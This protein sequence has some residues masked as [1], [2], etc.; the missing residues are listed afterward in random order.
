[1]FPEVEYDNI[2]LTHGM[3]ITIVTTT[4]NDKESFKLL[5][6]LG[7]PFTKGRS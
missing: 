1:M 2:L 5:E 6:L 7:F 4:N 3:N